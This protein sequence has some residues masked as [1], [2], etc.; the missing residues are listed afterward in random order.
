M[1]NLSFLIVILVLMFIGGSLTTMFSGTD[2]SGPIS[3]IQQTDDPA[4]STTQAEP[5]QAEQLFLLVV[6]V[7]LTVFGIGIGTAAIMWFL[8]RE[9][10]EAKAAP[11]SSPTETVSAAKT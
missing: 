11:V 1:K 2:S 5:W 6:F 4:A 8:H 9:I 7:M 3:P 10:S